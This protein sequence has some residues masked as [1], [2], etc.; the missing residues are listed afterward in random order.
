MKYK[1][2]GDCV[3]KTEY[4]KYVET[5]RKLEHLKVVSERL[6]PKMY[7]TIES[8][9]MGISDE[10]K[11]IAVKGNKRFSGK[12]LVKTMNDLLKESEMDEFVVYSE[13]VGLS[14]LL[15]LA[16]KQAKEGLPYLMS[17]HK[18]LVARTVM[19]NDDV[20]VSPLLTIF[21]VRNLLD[22]LSIYIEQ[23]TGRF[24]EGFDLPFTSQ[25]DFDTFETTFTAVHPL[26]FL[27]ERELDELIEMNEILDGVV[28]E[29]EALEL[30]FDFY[31]GFLKSIKEMFK[32]EFTFI[33][34][35]S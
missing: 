28:S 14:T 8:P 34:V 7:I 6:F 18:R 35:A 23:K 19:S 29:V 13:R 4:K 5:L 26:D 12:R 25:L 24:I 16:P 10:L 31:D 22:S 27:E 33:S 30:H 32:K 2:R 15:Y 17:Y 11:G 3:L 9:S 21:D 20:D 1:D